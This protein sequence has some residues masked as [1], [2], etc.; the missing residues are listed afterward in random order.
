VSTLDGN[1]VIFDFDH[2]ITGLMPY[3]NDHDDH[4]MIE[5]ASA[6]S[7]LLPT[8]LRWWRW[9]SSKP[10]TTLW[11]V[12]YLLRQMMPGD[13]ELE[14]DDDDDDTSTSTFS[15]WGATLYNALFRKKTRALRLSHIEFGG[16]S[17]TVLRTFGHR[18]LDLATPQG[19]LDFDRRYRW[20]YLPL[21]A[22]HL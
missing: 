6:S 5:P 7:A 19:R 12:K 4:E 10:S 3:Y 21:G 17:A 18:R 11:N 14:G 1:L 13:D 8:L 22:F 15:R 16:P 9:E 20:T 2:D